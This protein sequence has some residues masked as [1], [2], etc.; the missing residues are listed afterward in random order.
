MDTYAEKC[1][2]VPDKISDSKVQ[3]TRKVHLLDQED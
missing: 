1:L 2:S 3:K